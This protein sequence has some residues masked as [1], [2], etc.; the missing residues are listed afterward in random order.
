MSDD[1]RCVTCIETSLLVRH[2]ELCVHQYVYYRVVQTWDMSWCPRRVALG[3]MLGAIAID[4][5]SG[6]VMHRYVH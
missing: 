4:W 5:A 1:L 2:Y 6:I 3:H